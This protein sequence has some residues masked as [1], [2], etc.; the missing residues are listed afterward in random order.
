MLRWNYI[1]IA[2]Y[3]A[4]EIR[5]VYMHYTR[6]YLVFH[7]VLRIEDGFSYERASAFYLFLCCSSS[8][9]GPASPTVS[10]AYLFTCN[11]SA[12]TY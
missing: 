4:K 12:Y 8:S 7:R 6:S 11:L 2:L 10:I 3:G 1:V 9:P 5:A